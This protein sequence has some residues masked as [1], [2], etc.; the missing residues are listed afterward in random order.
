M[1]PFRDKAAPAPSQDELELRLA[2]LQRQFKELELHVENVLDKVTQAAKRAYKRD[3]DA[4]RAGDEQ[5]ALPLDRDARLKAIR[6][7]LHNR[8]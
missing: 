1:W 6:G 7:R 8:G 4:A 3:A 2:K 5:T